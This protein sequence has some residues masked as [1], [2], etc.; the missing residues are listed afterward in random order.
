VADW[1]TVGVYRIGVNLD[2]RN[3]VCPCCLARTAEVDHW[4]RFESRVGT[5]IKHHSRLTRDEPAVP[6]HPGAEMDRGGMAEV[7]GHQLLGVGHDYLDGMTSTPR[8]VIAQGHVHQ[9]AFAA[10]VS[11]NGYQIN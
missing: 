2:M 11:P 10:Q 8:Q 9:G 1:H 3:T 4:R 6:C 5:A 7:S